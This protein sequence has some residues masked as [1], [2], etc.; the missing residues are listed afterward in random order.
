MKVKTFQ[1]RLS[2]EHLE[3]DTQFIND[4]IEFMNVKRVMSELITGQIERWSIL[5][6]YEDQK[7]EST[8]SHHDK[9]SYSKDIE[10]TDSENEIFA[11]LREWRL[12]QATQL[13]KP[14][15]VVCSNVELISVV[16]MKPETKGDLLKLKGFGEHKIAKYG[17]DIITILNSF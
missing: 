8:S 4:S 3:S 11:A 17:N 10:L 9:I 5:I 13:G 1:I 7:A 16:K 2:K 12:D 15:F 14:A 6:F